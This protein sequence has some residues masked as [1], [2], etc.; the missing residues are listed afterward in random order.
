MNK[1]YN[2]LLNENKDLRENNNK[3]YE[4]K[5]ELEKRIKML[6]TPKEKVACS[7]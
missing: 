4:K 7:Y 6:K 3:L 2:Y 5:Q 1:E